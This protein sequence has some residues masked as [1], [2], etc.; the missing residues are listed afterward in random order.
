MMG[1]EIVVERG[2]NRMRQRDIQIQQAGTVGSV[3]SVALSTAGHASELR[4]TWLWA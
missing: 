1:G 2:R 4:E 3:A